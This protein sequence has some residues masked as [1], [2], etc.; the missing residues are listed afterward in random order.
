MLLLMLRETPMAMLT[1]WTIMDATV[2]GSDDNNN[3][4]VLSR[5]Y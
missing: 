4:S 3:I 2:V 1:A 5:M